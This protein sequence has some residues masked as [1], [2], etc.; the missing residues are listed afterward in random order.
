[1]DKQ[2]IHFPMQFGSFYPVV[3]V[4]ATFILA[5]CS[6]ANHQQFSSPPGSMTEATAT[7]SVARNGNAMALNDPARKLIHTADISCRVKDVYTATA[8]FE[9]MVRA[10][11]GQVMES[12]LENQR[13]AVRLQPYTTDSVRQVQEYTTTAH[14]TV[15][16]PVQQL[17]TVLH[18][19]AAHADF[20]ESRN[21]QLEDATV[22]YI[23]N[24]LM[25]KGAADLTVDALKHSKKTNEVLQVSEYAD[26]HKTQEI[27]RTMENMAIDD[28]VNYARFTVDLAQPARIDALVIPDTERLMQPGLGQRLQLVLQ[29]LLVFIVT[30]WPLLLIIALLVWGIRYF[31]RRSQIRLLRRE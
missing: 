29:S 3:A 31:S 24:Q 19:V 15:R 16:V 7:D 30:I 20:I 28:K 27:S 8:S 17:D 22:Q 6:D 11:G 10:A 9:T 26:E 23:G 14:I 18:A 5:S 21:L 1:M 13:S 2:E 4:L 12:H 25:N